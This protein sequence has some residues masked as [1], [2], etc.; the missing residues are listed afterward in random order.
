ME[1]ELK[2]LGVDY[3]VV[4]VEDH[5]EM[6]SRYQIRHS[7]NLLINDELVCRGQPDENELKSLLKMQD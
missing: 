3:E 2:D 6:V 1:K 7:P 5:P 4:F